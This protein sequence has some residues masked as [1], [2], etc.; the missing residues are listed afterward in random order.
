LIYRESIDP[1]VG[2][3]PYQARKLAVAGIAGELLTASQLI[4]GY[5]EL[6]GDWTLR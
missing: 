3:M 4:M 2:L 1:A 5:G 6:V